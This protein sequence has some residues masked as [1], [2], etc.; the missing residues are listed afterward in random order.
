MCEARSC[1][2]A[3]RLAGESLR[4]LAVS[5]VG[6]VVDLSTALALS[7]L[8]LNL[9]LAATIGFCLAVFVNFHLHGRWTFGDAVERSPRRLMQFFLTSVVTLAV[10]LLTLEALI[11][12]NLPTLFY[13]NAELLV[14]ATGVSLMVNFCLSKFLVFR[15]R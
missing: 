9:F 11:A 10:R 12:A 7:L 13:R 5:I 15:V 1:L 2:S 4:F 8:G 14:L 6:L 3:N